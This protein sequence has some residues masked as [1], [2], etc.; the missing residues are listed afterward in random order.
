VHQSK[1]KAMNSKNQL[2]S[3]IDQWLNRT[4]AVV[5]A[6]CIGTVVAGIA[7]VIMI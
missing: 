2:E 1:P 5:I 4:W 3:K 6:L 7:M